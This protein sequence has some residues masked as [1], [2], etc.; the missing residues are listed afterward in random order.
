MLNKKNNRI[1]L[2]TLLMPAIAFIMFLAPA[3]FS[4]AE[5]C[6]SS[7]S[8]NGTSVTF[9]G[10][11]ADMG[12]DTATDV[13][14]EYGQTTD[15]GQKTD[16]LT[17]S[18]PKIYCIVVSGL[19]PNTTYNYRAAA[20]NQAGIG[21]G[22]NKTLTTSESQSALTVSGSQ[23]SQPANETAPAPYSDQ[24]TSTVAGA[25]T[26]I[27]TGL[28]NNVLLDSFILPLLLTLLI[29]WIL[30]SRILKLE[31]WLEKRKEEHKVFKSKKTLQMKVG[32]IKAREFLKRL[33]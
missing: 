29:V 30:K 33:S 8:V 17:L 7:T 10:E 25:A 31:E 32:K 16:K 26:Q 4:L 13:W 24:A 21:Y 6:P 22:E 5:N 27:S 12:G 15:Y 3:N 18:D 9:V 20:G 23:S 11:L 1:A 14:F 2:K 28:T 19:E